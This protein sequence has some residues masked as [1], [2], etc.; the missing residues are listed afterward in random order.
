M[1]Q[2]AALSQAESNAKSHRRC[3]PSLAPQQVPRRLSQPDPDGGGT[4]TNRCA[5]TNAFIFCQ[6]HNLQPTNLPAPG[7]TVHTVNSGQATADVTITYSDIHSQTTGAFCPTKFIKVT[8]STAT[9]KPDNAQTTNT[10]TTSGHT[11]VDLGQTSPPTTQLPSEVVGHLE[12][13]SAPSA[14]HS[15]DPEAEASGGALECAAGQ[16]EG[17]REGDR[18]DRERDREDLVADVEDQAR[19]QD[20]DERRPA[21]WCG[22]GSRRSARG[23]RPRGRR[24]RRRRRRCRSR[25]GCPPMTPISSETMPARMTSSPSGNVPPGGRRALG[26]GGRERGLVALAFR[27]Q[28]PQAARL[29]GIPMRP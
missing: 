6:V 12:L 21:G 25:S 2:Q 13:E 7:W 3:N 26:C 8:A 15:A 18:A 29:T 11:T 16:V 22:S 1:A 20:E 17:D 27:A 4:D 14:A 19:R 28:R 5:P 24:G 9:A 10:L 23:S